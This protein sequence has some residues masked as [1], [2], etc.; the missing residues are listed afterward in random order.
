[1]TERHA[2]ADGLDSL[3][4]DLQADPS[5]ADYILTDAD[6]AADADS[7]T[8][9]L[10]RRA[11]RGGLIV[12]TDVASDG[13]YGTSARAHW[14]WTCKLDLT[15]DVSALADGTTIGMPVGPW[16][17]HVMLEYEGDGVGPEDETC[18][19]DDVE[20]MLV[21]VWRC[22]GKVLARYRITTIR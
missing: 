8:E 12:W 2:D 22:D 14:L 6:T 1:M 4:R 18:F 9:W 13:F 19:A 15:I 10:L 21:H 16:Q 5:G 7:L 11:D 20:T 17:S 3:L